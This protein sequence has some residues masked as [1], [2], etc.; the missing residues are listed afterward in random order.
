MSLIE[1]VVGMSDPYKIAALLCLCL[2]H[3]LERVHAGSCSCHVR[4][5]ICHAYYCSDSLGYYSYYGGYCRHRI[6]YFSLYADYT[7]TVLAFTGSTWHIEATI[8]AT[9]C[10]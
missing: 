7:V 9:T 10:A 6:G 1:N 5:C 2:A 4:S 8:G 3:R